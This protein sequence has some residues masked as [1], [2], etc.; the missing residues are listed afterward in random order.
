MYKPTIHLNGSDPTV[1]ADGYKAALDK[2]K[3]AA[4]LL[5]A[6]APHGRD[7]YPQEGEIG[8]PWGS[9]FEMARREHADRMRKVGEVVIDLSQLHRHCAGEAARRGR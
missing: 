3:E 1:L 6:C 5:A 9:V 2:L 7:Y 8:G 4:E